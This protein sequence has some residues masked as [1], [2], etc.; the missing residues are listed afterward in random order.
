[1][2]HLPNLLN[3]TAFLGLLCA[4]LAAGCKTEL[5]DLE[6]ATFPTN[7]DVFIDGFSA[8]LNYA[9]F[10]GSDVRAFDVDNDIVYDGTAS[11]RYDVPDFEDPAG[12]YAGGTYFTEVGRDL[13]GYTALTFW[14]RASKA[15]NIDV[16][17]IGNDLAE[18]TYQASI[19]G[20]AINTDWE[21]YYI[22]IPDPS[23]LTQERG[24]FFYSEGPE[25]NRGYTFWVDEVQFENVTTLGAPEGFVFNGEDRVV[26]GQAG[27][28]YSAAG[29]TIFSLPDGVDQRVETAAAYFDYTSS[30]TLIAVV[31][32]IG[33]VTVRDSG[34]AVITA[35]L[36][37]EPTTGSLTVSSSGVGS[38]P[39]VAAPTPTIP[40]SDVISLFSDAYVD[41]P[42]D[43]YN[44]YWEFSTT[45][46]ET[47]DLSGN[48][49][50]RYSQLN[51]VG[52]QFTDPTIDIS[53]MTNVRMDIW[54]PDPVDAGTEFKVLLFDIGP[55]NAFEGGDD[56]GFEVTVSSPTLQSGEWVT[57]D[58]P[59]SAFAGLTGRSNLAQVVLSGD[60]PNVYLDNLFFYDDGNGGG[61]GNNDVPAVAAPTPSRPANGVISLFSDAY[62]DVLVDTWRTD[63]SSAALTDTDVNGD[64]VKRYTALD[65]VGIET[66]ME[67]IDVSTMTHFHLDVWTPD[68]TLFGVKLVDFGAD[69]AFDGGDDVEQQLDFASPQQGTWVGYDIPLSDFNLLT[70]RNNIAQLILVAQP[71]GAA[72][73]YV[74]N[75]YFYDENAGGTGGNEPSTAAPTPTRPASTVI[76]LFSDAYTD[77][78][79][80]TWRTDW[81]SAAFEDVLIAGNATKKYTELDFV[82]IETV[83]NQIDATAVTHIHLDVWTPDATLFGIKLVDFG[84]D[85]AFDGGDD[86]EQQI[87]FANPAQGQ[88]ISYDIPLSEFAALTTRSNLAQFILVGQPTGNATIYVDNLYFYQE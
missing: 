12:A 56:S 46:S 22:P 68:A 16:I 45:Q 65:F 49:A 71:S 52:I 8:G 83:A 54:T 70:T 50:I 80:D 79:V 14:A 19:G 7:G 38:Q 42:V 64:A 43:F 5:E 74:D 3:R 13:S 4:L 78:P 37:G 28:T 57:I 39:A 84:A 35:T 69:G 21:K 88:W 76:S 27:D 6:P 66:V 20:L 24:M 9:A 15:A 75:V 36:A 34:M 87:D 82:G 41:E 26:A 62:D 11:M 53:S 33:V 51:F 40:A 1:M 67:Q 31:S 2:C 23:K 77:V 18:S 10:G 60:L 85:G 59:L 72:T 48:A 73:V 30:D 55:N 81:S 25:D 44:G 61:G 86:V 47:V 63:W 29:Y 17:G 32:D 58:L